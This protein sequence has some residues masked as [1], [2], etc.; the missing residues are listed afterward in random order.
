LTQ[1]LIFVVIILSLCDRRQSLL[2]VIMQSLNIE[3]MWDQVLISAKF[4][5]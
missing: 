5:E 3:K 4:K 1:L 2:D